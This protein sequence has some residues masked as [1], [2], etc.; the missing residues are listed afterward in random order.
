MPSYGPWLTTWDKKEP[1]SRVSGKNYKKYVMCDTYHTVQKSK[2]LGSGRS[3]VATLK[4]KGIDGR[5]TPGVVKGS[6]VKFAV[7]WDTHMISANLWVLVRVCYV[8]YRTVQGFKIVK[9]AMSWTWFSHYLFSCCSMT[10][11]NHEFLTRLKYT[12][13]NFWY[14]VVSVLLSLCVCACAGVCRSWSGAR[15]LWEKWLK[16]PAMLTK[17]GA[18][19][20]TYLC[21]FL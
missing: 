2:S 12:N 3:M 11:K 15:E 9:F 21:C 8:W 7:T 18:A 16:C 20:L 13:H 1:S 5:A 17:Q 6:I 4:L 10:H 14:S 19:Y